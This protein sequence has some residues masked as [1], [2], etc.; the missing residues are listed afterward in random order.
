MKRLLGAVVCGGEEGCREATKGTKL[1]LSP[2]T[3]WVTWDIK[4]T[5]GY[6]QG[7]VHLGCLSV[8]KRYAVVPY[9]ME[10][11]IGRLSSLKMSF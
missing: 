11:S 4:V 10:R 5:L 8:R 9:S 7:G 2:V 3:T 1:Q 6:L